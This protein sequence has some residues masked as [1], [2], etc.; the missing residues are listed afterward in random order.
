MVR[1]WEFSSRLGMRTWI[2]VP[3]FAPVAAA[4]AVS[5]F[6]K[7]IKKRKKSNLFFS[8]SFS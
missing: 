3:Y 1:E 8:F 7:E 4:T 6:F 2:A 5:F